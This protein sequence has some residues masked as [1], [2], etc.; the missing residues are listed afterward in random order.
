MFG[1]P[2]TCPRCDG[3]LELINSTGSQSLAVAILECAPC[4]CQWEA[5]V[6]L[7]LHHKIKAVA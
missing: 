6:R 4:R 3:P 1:L 5:T 2:A 7:K